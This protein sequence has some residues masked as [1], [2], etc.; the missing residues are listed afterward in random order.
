MLCQMVAESLVVLIGLWRAAV[1]PYVHQ[2]SNAAGCDRRKSSFQQI[3]LKEQLIHNIFV[4]ELSSILHLESVN[5]I[6][7]A[8]PR[9]VIFERPCQEVHHV[10]VQRVQKRRLPIQ[11]NRTALHVSHQ[12]LVVGGQL[13]STGGTKLWLSD[14][15]GGDEQRSE[16]AN[17]G[18]LLHIL[19]IGCLVGC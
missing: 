3:P 15:P 1:T 14:G 2:R 19:A 11:G 16:D 6:V 18:R 13:M 10:V 9:H 7:E 17:G 12:L 5:G 4:P 8:T